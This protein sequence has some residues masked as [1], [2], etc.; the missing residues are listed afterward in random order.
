MKNILK[1]IPKVFELTMVF[2]YIVLGILILFKQGPKLANNLLQYSF[3]AVLL[4]YG[5]FRAYQV[6]YKYYIQSK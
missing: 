4:L 3:G 1:N 5:C 6:Y 2:V